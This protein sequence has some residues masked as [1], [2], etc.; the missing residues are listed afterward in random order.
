MNKELKSVPTWFKANK[1][2]INTDKTKWNIFHTTSKKLFMSTK[3]LE[4][5]IDG[6]TLE[7]E[8]VTKFLRVFI[9]EN[10]TWKVHINTIATKIPKS[11]LYIGSVIFPRKQ[12]NEL[13]FSFGHSYLSYFLWGKSYEKKNIDKQL[14]KAFCWFTKHK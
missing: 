9:D 5:I 1:I 4:L 2:Y 7:Q 6:I 3:N 13:Y 8:T 12:L 14:R 10:V 11:I